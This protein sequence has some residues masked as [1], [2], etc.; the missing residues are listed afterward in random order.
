MNVRR[1]KTA[2]KERSLHGSWQCNSVNTGSLQETLVSSNGNR[3][4][5]DLF[6][7]VLCKATFGI[8]KKFD[9]LNIVFLKKHFF[10]KIVVLVDTA[11]RYPTFTQNICCR[12]GFAQRVM[13][14]AQTGFYT[15]KKNISRSAQP[16]ARFEKSFLRFTQEKLFYEKVWQ[17]LFG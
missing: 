16:R 8:T 14:L 12:Q 4:W 5:E 1:C 9:F 17:N 3:S 11:A 2:N 7:N 10:N 15:Q 13:F 6:L